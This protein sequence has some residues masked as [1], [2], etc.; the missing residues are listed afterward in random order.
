ME[1]FDE[2][3]DYYNYLVDLTKNHEYV[4]ITNEWL[5]YNNS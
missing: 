4:G 1:N 2:I 3:T 5:I